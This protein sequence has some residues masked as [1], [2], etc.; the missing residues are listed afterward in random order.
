MG[1]LTDLSSYGLPDVDVYRSAPEEGEQIRGGL[2]LIHEIWG[3]VD[4]I[5]DVADRLAAE[6]YLVYAPDLLSSA[7]IT[8]EVGEELAQLLREP[9]EETR[10][11]NQAVMRQKT[12]PVQ[13]PEFAAE[14]VARLKHVVDAL[15][16]EPAIG[17][18]IG[19]LGF[20]F[21][22]TYSFALA[23]ADPRVRVAVPFY[24]RAPEPEAM[25][26]IGCPV[27]GIYGQ[28]DPALIEALPSVKEDMAAAGVDFETVVYPEARHAFFND[29]NPVAYRP[30]DAADAWEHTLDFVD[31]HLA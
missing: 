2:V 10:T 5:K 14:T 23:A 6:G 8:P 21:G 31:R 16:D 4:H 12:A 26:S 3:L 9:D 22:G 1:E 11:A 28:H 7:G 13:S 27:L 20:C 18:R 25:G 29:T 19:V 30:D 17:D 24:G 15:A